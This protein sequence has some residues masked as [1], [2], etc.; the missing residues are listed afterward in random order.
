[1]VE[2]LRAQDDRRVEAGRRRDIALA[3]PLGTAAALATMFLPLEPR[4][5]AP[6]LF[7]APLVGLS[8]AGGI[9]LGLRS[10]RPNARLWT[11]LA[12]PTAEPIRGFRGS[13]ALELGGWFG[14]LLGAIAMAILIVTFV[15]DAAH[16]Q[17]EADARQLDVIRSRWDALRRCLVARAP[18]G[19]D[20]RAVLVQWHEPVDAPRATC[21]PETSALYTEA[22]KHRRWPLQVVGA[23]E[24]IAGCR[25][26]CAMPALDQ[27]R[28]LVLRHASYEFDSGSYVWNESK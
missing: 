6:P 21:D 10:L 13:V 27:E 26:R 16:R 3:A 18:E 19:G 28:T 2:A 11:V 15:A 20:G 8:C 25:A 12:R 22:Q 23:L 4:A 1:M 17:N 5:I 14:A 24:G 7:L 9:V